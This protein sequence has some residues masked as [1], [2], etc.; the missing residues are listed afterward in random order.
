M[1]ELTSPYLVHVL[2]LLQ[3][4][5]LLSVHQVDPTTGEKVKPAYQTNLFLVCKNDMV[6][7]SKLCL[8]TTWNRN[9]S[10]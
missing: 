1:G 9:N 3:G 4:L 10:A 2:Y 6:R 8:K 7:K 5:G